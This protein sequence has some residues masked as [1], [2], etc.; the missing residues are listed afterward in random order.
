MDLEYLIVKCGPFYQ[1]RDLN[2]TILLTNYIP[3]QGNIKM[4]LDELY[5]TVNPYEAV[6]L[7]ALFNIAGDFNQ[8]N[9][10]KYFTKYYQHSPPSSTPIAQFLTH[11]MASQIICWV[12]LLPGYRQRLNYEAPMSRVIQRCGLRRLQVYLRNAWT[13]TCSGPHYPA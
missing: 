3:L 1:L 9:F 5:L 10:R 11:I 2:S 6:N 8:A 12:L 4:E 13:R 7:D